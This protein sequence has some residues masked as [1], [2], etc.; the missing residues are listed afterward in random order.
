M[1]LAQLIVILYIIVKACICLLTEYALQGRGPLGRLGRKTKIP[2]IIIYI[3]IALVPCLGAYLPNGPLKFF[4]MKWGNIWLGFF[5]YYGGLLLILSGIA[6]LRA[7]HNKAKK[8]YLVGYAFVIAFWAGLIINV[9]G[10]HHAQQPK[11][12]NY[13]IDISEGEERHLKIVLIA[14]LHL[15][16]NSYPETT[17]KMVEMVNACEPDI[18]LVGGDIFT[19]TYAGLSDPDRYAAAL[20]SMKAKYG[21]YAVAGNHDVEESLFGGFAISPY[22]EAFRTEE[23]D[24]FFKDAGFNML[25]DEAVQIGDTGLTLVGRID[26]EKAGDGTKD[27]LSAEE[28]LKGIEGQVLVLEHEPKEYKDL[29]AAGTDLVLSGHTHNGQIFPGNFVVPFFN[30]NGYGVKEVYN[31]KTMVTA[32]VGFYGAPIRVGTDSEI[33]V[34]DLTY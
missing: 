14:D 11:V 26:E 1:E 29:S 33:S 32:G 13:S 2:R 34:I 3:M 30:E 17:E 18:I 6:V 7:G 12:E 21:V 8:R 24:N 28:L 16:V 4:C 31:M 23:M 25:Y 20:S 22:T 5:I 9:Y 15:S 10:L 27:R 19:S